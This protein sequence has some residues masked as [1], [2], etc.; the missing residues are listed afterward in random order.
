[1]NY[2]AV[3]ECN[4]LVLQRSDFMRVMAE[5][6][7]LINQMRKLLRAGEEYFVQ[8]QLPGELEGK[9]SVHEVI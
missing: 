1:M 7:E 4:I 5:N 8:P 6:V 2:V 9:E 3:E